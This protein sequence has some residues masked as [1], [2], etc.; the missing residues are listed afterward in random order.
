MP[1]R[2]TKSEGRSI[3]KD[4]ETLLMIATFPKIF[5]IKLKPKAIREPKRSRSRFLFFENN[6]S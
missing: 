6:N 1:I 5:N 3:A 2:A 4:G